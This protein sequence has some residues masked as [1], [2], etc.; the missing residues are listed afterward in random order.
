MI[1]V[2]ASV[3]VKPGKR[4]DLLDLFKVNLSKVREE[5]GCIRYFPAVD[6]ATGLPPQSLDENMV[7]V[8]ETWESVEALKDHLGTPHMA[9]FFEKEKSLVEGSTIKILQEA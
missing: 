3:K 8:I 9:A 7:T 1:H 5:K 2:I 4:Q 6:I